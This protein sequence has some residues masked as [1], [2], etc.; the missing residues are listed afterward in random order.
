M[1]VILATY[2]NWDDPPSTSWIRD[3]DRKVRSEVR[4]RKLG[5]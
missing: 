3:E 2:T 1:G 5:S 4:S